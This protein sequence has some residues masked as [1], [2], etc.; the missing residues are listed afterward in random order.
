MQ[1]E[2]AASMLTNELVGL[3]RRTRSSL[4][5]A[6][7]DGEPAAQSSFGPQLLAAGFFSDYKELVFPYR[8]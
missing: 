2:S 7:I 6:R 8:P 1:S 3:T 4:R 5:L